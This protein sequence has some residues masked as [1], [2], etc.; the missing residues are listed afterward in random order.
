M[1]LSFILLLAPGL[2]AASTELEQARDKQDRAA[3][4]RI[5]GNLQ[6]AANQHPN[7]ANAQYQLALAQSYAAEV[8]IEV[9]DKGQAQ[10]TAEAGIKVAEK[11][12][13]MNPNNAEYHRIL[14]TLCGQVIP[15]NVLFGM[16]YGKCAKESIDKAIQLDP[17]SSVAYLSRGIGNYYLPPTFGGGAE[18]AIKDFDE[19]IRLNPKSSEAHLWRGIAL[20]KLN[21]NAEA[22]E[23]LAK[24]VQLNPQRLWAKQQL[25]KTP[26]K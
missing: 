7:D 20:R 6:N 12:V 26:A 8:A 14:G 23:E 21:R 24:S 13:Q 17:K 5:V 18:I 19:A 22:H 25:D 9:K 10:K 1:R 3:L 11:A 2:F 15:A 16:R 4:D